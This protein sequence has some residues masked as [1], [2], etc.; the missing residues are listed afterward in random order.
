[1][2]SAVPPVTDPQQWPELRQRVTT[3]G[4]G[5]GAVTAYQPASVTVELDTGGLVIAPVDAVHVLTVA[6]EAA[7]V[8]A[9]AVEAL[10]SG[11]T[12]RARIAALRAAG[13]DLVRRDR[14]GRPERPTRAAR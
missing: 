5:R 13:F 14:P 7:A 10:G 11:A 3:T 9:Q 2:S 1:M 12:G 8:E 4:G 6:D